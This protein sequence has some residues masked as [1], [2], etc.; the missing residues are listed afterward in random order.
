MKNIYNTILAPYITEKVMLQSELE[1]K[2]VFKVPVSSNKIEIKDA[3]EKIFSVK[4]EKVATVN[5]KGK[6]KRQGRFEGKR[7]DW[8]KAIVTLKEGDKIEY[9][10]GA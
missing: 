4:V 5:S 8:K 3:I 10:E 6:R 2:V 9:F 1:N 7:S